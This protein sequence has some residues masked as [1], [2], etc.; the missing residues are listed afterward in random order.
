MTSV[1]VYGDKM[2]SAVQA[3]LALVCQK[4]RKEIKF[5]MKQNTVCFTLFSN[6]VQERLHGNLVDSRIQILCHFKILHTKL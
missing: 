2:F 1:E 4:R 5:M 3:H 6:Y